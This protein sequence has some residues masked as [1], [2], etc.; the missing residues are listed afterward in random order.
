[1]LEN[2]F[3]EIETHIKTSTPET[4]KYGEVYTELDLVD[5]MLST[6][7][8]DFWKNPH[9][10]ILDPCSG[11]GNFPSR[12]ISKLMVG[13]VSFEE[14]ETKRYKWII[15]NIIYV[16]EIQ[17][18][19][20]EFYINLFN[21]NGEYSMNIFI[22]SFF[23]LDIKNDFNISRFDLIVGNPPYQIGN[24]TRSS[25]SIYD[26]FVDSSCS[27]SSIVLMITPSKWYSNP[28]MLKFRN[29]MINNYG[30]KILVDKKDVF[31]SVEIK[32]GVSYFLLDDGYKG[33][34]LFN[35][36]MVSFDNGLITNYDLLINKINKYEKF[37]YLLKSD[38]YFGVRNKDGRFLLEES[39]DT[40][41]CYVSKQN[42]NIKYLK[43]DELEIKSNHNKFKVF[44]PTAS[45]SKD[46]IS[47]LGRKI[48]GLP[49]EISS[50]SFVHFHFDTYAECESFISYL[51]TDTVK[52]LISIKKQTH[53]LKKDCFSLVPIV[54]LDRKWCDKMVRVYLELD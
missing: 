13:L 25:I 14:D 51:E 21:P 42:G 19:N 20:V 1:M 39:H 23:D 18:K 15:E 9:L 52:K 45:G 34:C 33:K 50:R 48:I 31:K 10:K 28:S 4:E 38:Q 6:L 46:N 12:I 40:V 53:L 47:E 36:E 27:I 2:I 37:S 41:K 11:V 3:Y 24:D 26:K 29:N 8:E 5:E 35:D 43:K 17:P 54:P 30:L 7:S 32:G 16:V 49:G 22:G 44:L